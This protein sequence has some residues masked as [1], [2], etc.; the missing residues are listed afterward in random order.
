MQLSIVLMDLGAKVPELIYF[1]L[2][3]EYE[4]PWNGT[5]NGNRVA[6]SGKEN[7]GSLEE[8]GSVS[9]V[10]ERLTPVFL[11]LL[12][13]WILVR[14]TSSVSFAEF[15][16]VFD[17]VSA[18]TTEHDVNPLHIRHYHQLLHNAH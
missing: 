12:Y 17:S 9:E 1:P 18:L 14:D 2:V 15:V 7:I 10:W 3:P 5:I 11:S 13:D 8:V 4:I 6:H 16:I